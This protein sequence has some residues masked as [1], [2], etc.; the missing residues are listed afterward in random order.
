MRLSTQS[1][2]QP[3]SPVSLTLH[4]TSL[5]ALSVFFSLLLLGT[6]L[7]R[8]LRHHFAQQDAEELNVVAQAVENVLRGPQTTSL[9]GAS[10]LTNTPAVLQ[11]QLAHAISGHHGVYFAVFSDELR[12]LYQSAQV[13]LTPLLA[14]APIT[15]PINPELLLDWQT[16]DHGYRGAQLMVERDSTPPLRLLVAAQV[17]FHHQFLATFQVTLWLT[18]LLAALI[19]ATIAWWAVRQGLRPL[20]RLNAVLAAISSDRLH[21]RLQPHQL[22]RELRP[23]VSAF[24]DLLQRLENQFTQL[25]NFSADI[26]HELR[27]PVTNLTT[28]TEVA[29]AA[30]RDVDEYREI[31]YSNLE[32]YG[33]LSATVS[34]MLWLAKTDHGL[35]IPTFTTLD[36]SQEVRDLFEFFAAWADEKRV[37]LQLDSAAAS[38][39]G[40]RAMLRRALSNLLTNA[41]RYTPENGTIN[42]RVRSL[43]QQLSVTVTNPGATI[44]AEHLPHLFDRFYRADPS[45]QRTGEGSGLGLSIVKAIVTCHGG[46][47]TVT[48]ADQRTTFDMRL[49]QRPT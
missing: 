47:I 10:S 44:A 18:I 42:V 32:E 4:V 8:E 46:N 3:G 6:L 22:P 27:T 36:L 40:D 38:L 39:Q 1:S 24:N 33:R 35:V 13:D 12:T 30:A 41:I 16:A 15:R 17:D 48:S 20:H 2:R 49:P 11:Q 7:Q 29:L 26:A 28:Q 19:T 34:D 14:T 5:V 37:T 25:V 23:L 21:L 31:L 43:S 45:R 9:R